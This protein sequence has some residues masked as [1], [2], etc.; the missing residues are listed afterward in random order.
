MATT[1]ISIRPYRTDD[2]PAL[3]EAALESVAEVRPFLP[4]CHPEVKLEEMR[5]WIEAQVA[6]FE[7]LKAFEFVILDAD[8][9]Y[10][11]G[12]GLNH[13]DE[14]YRRANLGYW[15][16]TSAA[17]RGVATEAVRQLVRWAFDSTDLIRLEVVVSTHN[18]ASLRVAE[19]ADAF[20]E[21]TLRKR[22]LLHGVA[23][24]AA[25]FSFVREI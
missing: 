19:K 22:L 11:G 1:E 21:G 24:D 12:C 15:V 7:T 20:R 10:L 14:V 5:T 23:H 18:A 25:V 13:I 17:G 3:H 6:A 4:W 8:G 16:R 9:R 2:A